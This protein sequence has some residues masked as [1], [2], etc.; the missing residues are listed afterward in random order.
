MKRCFPEEDVPKGAGSGKF[1]DVNRSISLFLFFL[2]LLTDLFG[3]PLTEHIFLLHSLFSSFYPAVFMSYGSGFF[4]KGQ[5]PALPYGKPVR[6]RS[7]QRIRQECND[8]CQEV[9]YLH[10]PPSRWDKVAGFARVVVTGGSH[11]RFPIF[12]PTLNRMGSPIQISTSCKKCASRE[13]FIK[14]VECICTE[15]EREFTVQA[16][17]YEIVYACQFQGFKLK[18]VSEI[19]FFPETNPDI[20]SG[21]KEN[22]KKKL[23]FSF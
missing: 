19:E 6:L 8:S 9:C 23:S 5:Q 22:K 21:K 13:D 12:R 1:Y 15:E 7:D 3:P 17:F 10:C 4:P 11:T 16:T 18:H 20:F 14:T 2:L